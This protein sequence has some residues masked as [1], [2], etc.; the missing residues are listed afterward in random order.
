MGQLKVNQNLVNAENAK[1]LAEICPFG[2][3]SYDGK[4][5]DVSSAC[6]MCKMCIK[7]GPA[8]VMEFV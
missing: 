7:K 4:K 6:K 5:L 1:V 3:I 2:A 8:G